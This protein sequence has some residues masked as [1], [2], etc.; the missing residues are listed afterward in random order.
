MKYV[1]GQSVVVVVVKVETKRQM[2]LIH[3]HHQSDPSFN[4]NSAAC[5]SV[6]SVGVTGVCCVVMIRSIAISYSHTLDLSTLYNTEWGRGNAYHSPMN[7]SGNTV[8]TITILLLLLVWLPCTAVM[9]LCA[10]VSTS[11]MEQM[12]TICDIRGGITD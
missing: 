3:S 7:S 6:K 10:V 5:S 1:C 2:I 8:P 12:C 11:T 9:L 4:K